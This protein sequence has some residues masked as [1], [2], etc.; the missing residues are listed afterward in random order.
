MAA[1]A[2]QSRG[3]RVLLVEDEPGAREGLRQI[4][5]MLGYDVTAA[6]TGEEALQLVAKRHFHL[7][8]TDL[9][10]PAVSGFGLISSLR[11]QH[12]LTP[13]IAMTGWGSHCWWELLKPIWC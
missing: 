6:A 2:P 9:I 10:I 7:I 1:A 13:I 5:S 11:Q 3:E 12:P 8:I 4:L